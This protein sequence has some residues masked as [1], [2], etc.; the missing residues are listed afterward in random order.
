MFLFIKHIDIE[1]PGTFGE[2]LTSRGIAYKILDLAKGKRLPAEPDV[3]DAIIVLGGPMNVYEEEKYPFLK[4][5]NLFIQKV[6]E[7]KIPYLG[8]CLGSQLLA[9]AAG[10]AVSKAS[11]KEVGFFPVELST[12]GQKDPL[13]Q[14][15]DKTFQAY[16]WHEDTF[17]M[18]KVATYLASSPIC[19]NQAFR[20][21]A[22]A[23]GLQF[24]VEITDDSI[25]AWSDA[26]INKEPD[27]LL[28]KKN[29]L[30]DYTL[31]KKP[32]DKM[33]R[34]LYDNFLKVV[35]LQKI[36]V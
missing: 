10:A 31:L 18:P 28:Q 17:A 20:V 25:K 32:F 6:I 13:F 26:Y 27:F 3:F 24:H 35:E 8:I 34:R 14:G 21:G 33:A 16:Q 7:K 15:I 23:Y 2:Y 5:E 30:D 22:C 1:G 29:M 12:Q 19:T 11:Q 36:S 9:K 4:E